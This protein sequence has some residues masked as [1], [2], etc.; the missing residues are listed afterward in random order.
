MTS[1]AP[2]PPT[3]GGSGGY[4]AAAV[5]MLLLIGGLVIWKLK[6]SDDTE[7]VDMIPTAPPKATEA[8]SMDEPAPPPPPEEEVAAPKPVETAEKKVSSTGGGMTGCSGTCGGTLSAQGQSALSAKGG[9]ARGCYN[10]ALR[11]NATLEGKMT[12]AVR[13]SP[14]GNVCSANVRN[15]SLNDPA[16]STCVA[17]MFRA[18][19]FPAPSGGCVDVEVPLNFVSKK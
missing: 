14:S 17:Q 16:V 3:K 12:V 7:I 1:Q 10:R 11:N 19:K 2:S 8:P 4:I 15:D 13:I 9:Q 18:G 6:S 5:I